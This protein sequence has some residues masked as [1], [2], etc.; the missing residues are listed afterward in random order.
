MSALVL[1]TGER[2]LRESAKAVQACN[3]YLRMGP[4]RSLAELHRQYIG[5]HGN[6]APTRSRNTLL[7]WSS[8]YSWSK[9]AE[10]YDTR[11]EA[12]KNERAREIMQ[13]GLALAHER[14]E[15]LKELAAFL[16]DQIKEQNEA[17]QY[18][19]VWLPDAKQIGSGKDAERVNLERF[20]SALI[21]QYRATLDDIAAE[22]GGRQ[23]KHAVDLTQHF[24]LEEWKQRARV[25][26]AA[27]EEMEELEECGDQ[28]R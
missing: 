1:L 18:D 22:T 16:E 11:L 5:I 6:A 3:D 15:K 8:R 19:N 10:T 24:D 9:R 13:T 26:R 2:Q 14:V 25:Q 7:R 23:R 12:E 21:E 17:G 20:N 28:D 27:V 4:G